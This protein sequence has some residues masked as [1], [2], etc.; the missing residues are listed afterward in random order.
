MPQAAAGFGGRGGGRGRGAAAPA[1]AG[2]GTP[3]SP[4]CGG[5][6]PAAA[7]GGRGGGRG[8]AQTLAWQP[9]IGGCESGFTIPTPDNADIVYASC[10]GNKVTRWDARTGTARS[11]EPWMVTL[12][13]PPNETKYR[14]HWTAPM[15]I[16]PF[17][18]KNVL[19]GCQNILKTSNGGQS[20]TEF[21]PDLSTKDPSKVVSNGGLVG[22]NLGQYN[23]EVVWSIEYSKIQ[24]NLIWAGT[25]DGKLWYTKDGGAQWNDVTK[26]LKDL[27][28]WGAF[29]Q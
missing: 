12:D 28:V 6:D 2:R 22:D 10:Y 18:T 5:A 8:G 29:N 19:Y 3:S 21:S 27:P 17:D 4:R 20:W 14:C 23:G 11:I 1:T 13:A 24:R 9:H 25:N 16:D 15:A 7:A 26:N